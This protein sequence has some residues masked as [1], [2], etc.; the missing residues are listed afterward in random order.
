[1][2]EKVFIYP[3]AISRKGEIKSFQIKLPAD[4]KRI[5]GIETTVKGLDVL[6]TGG[7]GG[8]GFAAFFAVAPHHFQFLPTYLAGYLRLQSC[9]SAN[10]FYAG[11]VWLTDNNLGYGNYSQ[12]N[13]FRHCAWTHGYRREEDVVSV[14]EPCSIIQGTYTDQAGERLNTDARYTVNVYLWYWAEETESSKN[15]NYDNQP[16]P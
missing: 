1:M 13:F 7:G 14:S 11:D 8:D 12:T 3:L 10:I 4:A 16:C 5:I 2:K 6:I 9:E 15:A